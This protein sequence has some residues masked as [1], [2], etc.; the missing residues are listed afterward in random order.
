MAAI[1]HA[2]RLTDLSEAFS[3]LE[4]ICGALPLLTTKKIA[5]LKNLDFAKEKCL[6][7]QKS[8]YLWWFFRPLGGAIFPNVA[9]VWFNFYFF[10]L[11]KK[12][13]VRTIHNLQN[14]VKHG[15]D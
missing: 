12:L 4:H 6:F 9:A 15:F 7:S 2:L 1:I 13:T 5:Y 3:S 10:F 11:K 14:Q 8:R